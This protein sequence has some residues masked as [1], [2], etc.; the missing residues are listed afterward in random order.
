MNSEAILFL[1]PKNRS[2]IQWLEDQGENVTQRESSLSDLEISALNCTFIISY[3]Y[4]HI[5]KQNVLALFPNRAINLHISY[6]PWNRGADP[7][8]WSFVE[9]TTK[10]VTIHYIDTGID[11]GDIIV[12]REVHFKLENETLATSY[13]KLQNEVESLFKQHWN[14]IKNITCPR[15][16]QSGRGSLH[17]RK[18]K[19]SLAHLLANGWNTP[20][21]LLRK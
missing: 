9:N 17:K 7:N 18:D 20:V 11:T 5:L 13:I 12:Q 1:G 2:L 16:K 6:L 4:R 21:S 3:G 8:L 10:G 15:V 14:S 19:N